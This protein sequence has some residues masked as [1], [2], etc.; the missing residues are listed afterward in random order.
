LSLTYETSNGTL[1][2]AELDGKP[3]AVESLKLVRSGGRHDLALR[4]NDDLFV[5][6]DNTLGQVP[7]PTT[8]ASASYPGLHKVEAKESAA[9]LMNTL[10]SKASTEE[11]PL[12]K[13]VLAYFGHEE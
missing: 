13:A 7:A 8:S 10:P 4:I 1:L 11:D 12:E 3:V 6:P 2:S 5:N 9:I